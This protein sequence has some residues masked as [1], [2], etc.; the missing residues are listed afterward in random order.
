MP[1]SPVV[2]NPALRYYNQSRFGPGIDPIKIEL[3]SIILFGSFHLTFFYLEVEKIL[4]FITSLR[5][6]DE[7]PDCLYRVQVRGLDRRVQPCTEREDDGNG[8]PG[9]CHLG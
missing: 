4:I 9:H 6:S 7:A 3:L 1:L 8:H 2:A 5:K